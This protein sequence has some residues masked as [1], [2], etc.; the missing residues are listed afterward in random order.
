MKGNLNG[1]NEMTKYRFI[2]GSLYELQGNAYIYVFK[3]AFCRTKKQ[4]IKAYE[5]SFYL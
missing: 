1:A 2:N 4:A 5:E 3:S